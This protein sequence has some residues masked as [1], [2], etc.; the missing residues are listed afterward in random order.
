MV[1][2]SV[3]FKLVINELNVV[4]LIGLRLDVGLFR[5]IK[6]GFS[7][8]V[9][10]R[11]VCLIMLLDSLD[12]NL[13]VVFC[14][15]FISFSFRFVNLFIS[16]GESFKCFCMGIWIFCFIVRDENRVFC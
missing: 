13:L 4:V 12:G 16:F 5:N 6:L 2:F 11:F 14:G 8:R 15:S 9:C 10:V 7:V 1:N 3:E